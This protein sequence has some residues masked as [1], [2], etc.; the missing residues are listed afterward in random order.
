[1]NYYVICRLDPPI[2]FGGDDEPEMG[3]YVLTTSRSFDSF[4]EAETYTRAIAP[5]REPKI[6]VEVEPAHEFGKND[7]WY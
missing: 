2:N 1:M 7:S 6:L 3:K 4:D 5:A